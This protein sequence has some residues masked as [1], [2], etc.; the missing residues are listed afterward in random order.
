MRGFLTAAKWVVLDMVSSL[1]FVGLWLL[2]GNIPL[3]MG[4]GITLGVAQI[5]WDLVRGRQIGAMQWVSVVVIAG[6][7]AAALITNDPRFVMIKPSVIYAAVGVAM[8][9]P[10]WMNRYL[11]PIAQ[12]T[13]SDIGVIF[14]FIWAGLMF[15]TAA[16]NIVVALNFTAATWIGFMAVYPLASKLVLFLVQYA[17]MRF[18]GL[19]RF[20]AMPA[21]DQ[22]R[23]RNTA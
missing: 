3:A 6:S 22:A 9:R 1:L 15:A 20:R 11:P 18:I 12:A 2:T 13:I 8:L 23:L 5:G 21:I 16:L 10:G 17:I 19:R 7:G 14:G 4:L